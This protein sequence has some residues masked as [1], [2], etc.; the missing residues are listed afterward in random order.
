MPVSFRPLEGQ[1]F[2]VFDNGGK[3][4]DH[5]PYLFV[6]EILRTDAGCWQVW[7]NGHLVA[8]RLPTF[9]AAKE[10][11]MQRR[12]DIFAKANG[13]TLGPPADGWCDVAVTCW[14]WD[15]AD[16]WRTLI[17]NRMLDAGHDSPRIQN[18]LRTPRLMELTPR[19]PV[20]VVRLPDPIAAHLRQSF[21]EDAEIRG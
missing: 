2:A 20:Y 19:G 18:M 6:G 11:Y 7:A 15:H 1:N 16:D 12:D 13:A 4:G 21:P 17:F 14:A 8:D 10:T 9:G 5:R 3:A